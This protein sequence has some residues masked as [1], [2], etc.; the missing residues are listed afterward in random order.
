LVGVAVY[1]KISAKTGF[2]SVGY[3]VDFGSGLLISFYNIITSII[4]NSKPF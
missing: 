1:G 4:S 3:L 2:F